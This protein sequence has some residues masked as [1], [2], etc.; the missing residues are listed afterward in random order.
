MDRLGSKATPISAPWTANSVNRSAKS[1]SASS[2]NQLCQ[3]CALEETNAVAHIVCLYAVGEKVI[4][5]HIPVEVHAVL[6]EFQAVFEEPNTLP[7]H[8]EWDH[9]IPIIPGAKPV[10]IRPYRYTRP[11]RR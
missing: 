1:A 8:R 7:P 6:Q 4:I 9:A 11:N 2:T 3:L 10:N 5:E